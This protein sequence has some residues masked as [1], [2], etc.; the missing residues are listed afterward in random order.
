MH[1][2]SLIVGAWL[3][4]IGD[5]GLCFVGVIIASGISGHVYEEILRIPIP[6][7]RSL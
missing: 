6:R 1:V 7:C 4:L 5:A 2:L 3:N